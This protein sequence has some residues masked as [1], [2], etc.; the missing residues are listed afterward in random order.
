MRT[1]RFICFVLFILLMQAAI[2][3]VRS[4]FTFPKV[5]PLSSHIFL[6]LDELRTYLH[7]DNT[8]LYFGDSVI[9][10]TDQSEPDQE[11]IT[12]KLQA[13]LPSMHVDFMTHEAQEMKIYDAYVTY[14]AHSGAHPAAIIIPL[15]L[16]SFNPQWDKNPRYQFLR[17]KFILTSQFPLLAEYFYRPLA[18]FQATGNNPISLDDYLAL[19]EYH[20]NGEVG[21][22][23]Q[24]MQFSYTQPPDKKS[25][26]QFLSSEFVYP[27]K[28]DNAI[29]LALAHLAKT[30]HDNHLNVIVYVSPA[31]YQLV[32][33]YMPDLGASIKT[34]AQ[35][36][37]NIV[38][39]QNLPCLDLSTSL[40]PSY[41]QYVGSPYGDEHME[42][43]GRAFVAQ[44][45][46][47]NFFKRSP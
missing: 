41:F 7:Q 5:D 17:E 38:K 37:C 43:K 1:S 27:L 8:I 33:K 28:P 15:N 6:E 46:Y 20:G 18:I 10:G 19:P 9:T 11:T 47:K 4:T 45:L 40:D 13:L 42:A 36:A 21:T 29:L 34:D 12:Q 22:V 3:Y 39:A 23:G 44:S 25:I 30:A 24:Y 16:R 35:M 26:D 32:G 14:I 31:N 2:G